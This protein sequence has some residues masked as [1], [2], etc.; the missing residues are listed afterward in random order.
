MTPYISWF[1]LALGLMAL[2]MVTNTFYLLVMGIA[3][4]FGGLAALFGLG[5]PFQYMICA[6]AGIIGIVI[7]R[8]MRRDKA[9]II[10]NQSLDIGQ[11]V[12]C[13]T[14]RK[15]GTARVQYRGTEWEAEA[16]SAATARD[17][18]HYIKA[19]RGS[20]LILTDHKAKD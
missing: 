17:G 12:Q 6:V 18:P 16:E 11:Q 13:I 7:L 4:A 9:Y 2:E 14:W 1:L 10:S 3:L 19:L 15:D 20:T 8:R 5:S